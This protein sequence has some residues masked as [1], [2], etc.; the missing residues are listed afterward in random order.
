MEERVLRSLDFSCHYISPV[1]FLERYLR[2]FGIDLEKKSDKHTTQLQKLSHQYCRF[3]LRDS[4]FLIYRP[5]QIAAAS[6][7]F[8]INISQSKVAPLIGINKIEESE[9][10]SLFFETAI[11]LGIT[12]VKFFEIDT[13]CPLRMWNKSV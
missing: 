1:P 13:K 11:H 5:S 3:M 7:L 10:K 6:L 4:S 9:M 8:A 2:I 12:G